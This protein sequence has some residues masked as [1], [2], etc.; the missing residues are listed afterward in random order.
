[1]TT[2]TQI[3]SADQPACDGKADMYRY[4]HLD[5]RGAGGIDDG[6]GVTMRINWKKENQRGN[7]MLDRDAE[8]FDDPPPAR[9]HVCEVCGDVSRACYAR[10][11]GRWLCH[12]HQPEEC[13]P[14]HTQ[15]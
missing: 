8:K 10:G 7:A 9:K 3:I 1:M 5:Y 6:S 13:K 2:Q 4:T 14:T 11:D 15:A 12:E